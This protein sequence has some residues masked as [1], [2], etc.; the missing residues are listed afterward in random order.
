MTFDTFDSYNTDEA[1][2]DNGTTAKGLVAAYKKDN[3]NGSAEDFYSKLNKTWAEDKNGYV[4]SA[5]DEAFTAPKP[6]VKEEVKE[7]VK[8]ETPKETTTTTSNISKADKNY[9]D[10]QFAITDEAKRKAIN[11]AINEKAT[12]F[13]NTLDT[14][15]KQG[16][17]YKS[18]DDHFIDQL[19]TFMFKRFENGE[20]GDPKSNDAQLRLAYFMVNGVQ[21]KLKNA[22][23][24]A[25]IAA[26]HGQMYADTTSDYEKYQA[27]NLEEGMQNRW[28]KYKAE[29]NNAIETLKNRG[30][31]EEE[32]TDAARLIAQN[33]NLQTAFNMV[34]ENKKGQHQVCPNRRC[35]RSRGM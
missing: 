30:L 9:M 11:D 16:A 13:N 35:Q 25:S 15:E 31:K 5:V 12:A 19:P 8:T 27:T 3:P 29:T 4:K 21:S 1:Y 6:E 23:N 22:A 17:A 33:Q 10:S 18:I 2:K 24:A 20:F 32:L 34:D 26:G 14:L 7:T 28:N